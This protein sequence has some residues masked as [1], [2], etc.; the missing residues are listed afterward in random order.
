M[1]SVYCAIC[2]K[3]VPL[4]E[5]HVEVGA[6]FVKTE[7]MNDVEEYAAHED[8]WRSISEGWIRPA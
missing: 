2:R 3:S 5:D 1:E 6:E 7:D 8:C 4:D